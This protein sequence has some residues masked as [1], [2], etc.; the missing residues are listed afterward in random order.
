MKDVITIGSATKDVFL[1]SQDFKLIK[2]KEFSTGVG[3]CFAFG[4]KVEMKD[5]FTD[6]GGGATNS[7]VTCA[8]LGLDVGVV[9]SVGF[10]S[11]GQEIIADLKDRNVDASLVYKHPTL[12]TGYSTI[13]LSS[14]GDRT[15]LVYRGAAQVFGDENLKNSK[16]LKA[17]WF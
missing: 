6:T 2:S 7:A 4:S 1:V 13:L 12:K 15:I 5:L 17:K 16:K 14:V 9:T 8:N 10:D 11:T 3:E